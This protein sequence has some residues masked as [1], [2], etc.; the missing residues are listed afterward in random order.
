[1][2]E[3]ASEIFWGKQHF[4]I[5]GD[6]GL[7]SRWLER[8]REHDIKRIKALD[9]R[10]DGGLIGDILSPQG[11]YGDMDRYCD[12]INTM[13]RR[14][15][16]DSLWLSLDAG[17]ISTTEF[18]KGLCMDETWANYTGGR[19]P[20]LNQAHWKILEPLKQAS[21]ANG[22]AKFHCFF[23]WGSDAEFAAEKEIMGQDYDS[24]CEGKIGYLDRADRNPHCE[25][26][27]RYGRYYTTLD[28]GSY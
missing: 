16:V 28:A 24:R 6:L 22:L 23:C 18:L 9:I 8:G 14:C 13:M 5:T 15:S 27:G 11:L 26:E 4:V 21:Q 1:M 20:G 12:L 7:G 2:N 3:E 17:S 25:D 19:L 10:I